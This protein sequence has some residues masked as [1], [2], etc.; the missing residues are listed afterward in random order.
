M[1]GTPGGQQVPSGALV[2]PLVLL[3]EVEAPGPH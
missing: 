1:L 3:V 2:L